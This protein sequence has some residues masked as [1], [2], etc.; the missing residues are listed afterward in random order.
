MHVRF[1]P[2]KLRR[3]EALRG[4]H[5]D[6]AAVGIPTHDEAVPPQ[7]LGVP[8]GAVGVE[9]LLALGVGADRDHS[10]RVGIL[11]VVEA[12]RRRFRLDV[13]EHVPEGHHGLDGVAAG[14]HLGIRIVVVVGGGG[15]VV[16]DRIVILAEREREPRDEGGG[17]EVHPPRVLLGGVVI[18]VVVI[19]VVGAGAGHAGELGVPLQ[20]RSR[21]VLPVIRCHA[22]ELERL[23]LR[24]RHAVERG[25]SL[26]LGEL[27]AAPTERGVRR[28]ER[29]QRGEVRRELGFFAPG[30]LRHDREH[31]RLALEPR[32]VLVEQR[33]AAEAE[34]DERRSRDGAV[35]GYDCRFR[36]LDEDVALL[37]V[38]RGDASSA[39]VGEPSNGDS[40]QLHPFLLHP[41]KIRAL[42]VVQRN[43]R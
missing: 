43:V 25:G 17:V 11:V 18:F 33:L 13:V 21:D 36:D 24:G 2:R 27:G 30:H 26:E 5:L 6:A 20:E 37:D 4:G 1:E 12:N 35:G 7:Q 42:R 32:G 3:G 41:R 22:R 28:A 34:G 16:F 29:G 10:Q 40:V 15:G 8:G 38:T 14:A 23:V 19:V 9:H 31:Q 39:G